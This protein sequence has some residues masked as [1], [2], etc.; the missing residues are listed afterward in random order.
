LDTDHD[1]GDT[2]HNVSNVEVASAQQAYQ[3]D[4]WRLIV[5]GMPPSFTINERGSDGTQY[6]ACK[7]RWESLA[8]VPYLLDLD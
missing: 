2:L 1:S 5:N 7:H 4:F 3:R 8:K 6:D